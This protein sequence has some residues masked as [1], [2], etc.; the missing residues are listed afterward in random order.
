MRLIHTLL[1]SGGVHDLERAPRKQVDRQV[2]LTPHKR[3]LLT[4]GG[5]VVLTPNGFG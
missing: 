2:N 4:H 5:V 1:R 3:R